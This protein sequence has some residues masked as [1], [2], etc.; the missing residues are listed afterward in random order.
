MSI[1]PV[2]TTKGPIGSLVLASGM[3]LHCAQQ[4]PRLAELGGA[5]DG[6]SQA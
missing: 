5:G 3:F 4:K 6:E 2:A 1:K